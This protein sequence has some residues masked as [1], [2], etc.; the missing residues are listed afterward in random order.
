MSD[1]RLSGTESLP[2]IQTER[3]SVDPPIH[4]VGGASLKLREHHRRASEQRTGVSGN[5]FDPEC[6]REVK[7]SD[8]FHR[9]PASDLVVAALDAAGNRAKSLRGVE[10]HR[11][12]SAPELI[13]K[14]RIERC[15]DG[16]ARTTSVER[17]AVDVERFERGSGGPSRSTG[18]RRRGP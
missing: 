3:R 17:N 18:K 2:T 6:D 14:V 16:H 9:A 7:N 10:D 13:P 8:A 1:E 15:S 12:R 11:R 4:K 5:A